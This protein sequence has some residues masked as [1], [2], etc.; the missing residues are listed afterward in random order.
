MFGAESALRYYSLFKQFVLSHGICVLA[1]HVLSKK[2][3]A[4]RLST[5]TSPAEIFLLVPEDAIFCLVLCSVI[6]LERISKVRAV[7]SCSTDSTRNISPKGNRF[8]EYP[9]L[10]DGV[11]RLLWAV[12]VLIYV[13]YHDTDQL[14]TRR[15]IQYEDMSDYVGGAR[16]V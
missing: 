2:N 10:G 8:F 13:H 5:G 1:F 15:R 11:S 4:I 12:Q 9:S 3:L 16:R 7:L 6:S 14:R